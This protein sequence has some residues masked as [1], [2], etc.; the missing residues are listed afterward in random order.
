[1]GEG[2][3]EEEERGLTVQF[4]LSVDLSHLGNGIYFSYL[5]NNYYWAVAIENR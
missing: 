3:K 5:G 2:E 4:S 1:M